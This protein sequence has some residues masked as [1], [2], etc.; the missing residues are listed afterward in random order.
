MSR[1]IHT[2]NCAIYTRKSSE[3]GLEQEFNSLHAQRE[4]CEAYIASQKHEG[5]K[6][7]RTHYEDGGYSGGTMERPGLLALIADIEQGRVQVVV[8]YKVDRLTR[9]LADFSKIIETFDAKG[10]SFVSVTQQ[11]N[12]TT[13]MGR[14]TLNVLLSFAQFEREVTG[15]R[16][17]DKIAASKK[18][19]M[20]MGG[21]VSLGYDC[22]ERKLIVNTAEADTVRHIFQRYLAL[23][24][25]RRLMQELADNGYCSKV[26]KTA[27][28]DLRGGKP[29]A[30][31]ALY[32]I[33]KNRLY[34]GEIVHKEESYPGEHDAI[35]DQDLWQQV[36]DRLSQNRIDRKN[37]SKAREPS[38]LTGIL[39]YAQGRRLTPSHA[40]KNGKRYR[41]YVTANSVNS[42][43]ESTG[44][45]I[46]L[47]ASEMENAVVSEIARFLKAPGELV[48]AL[49]ANVS[50]VGSRKLL[51]E[52]GQA[53]ATALSGNTDAASREFVCSIV[54]RVKIGRKTLSILLSEVA[55]GR[56]LL[57]HHKGITNDKAI[58]LEVPFRLRRR[59]VEAKLI[60]GNQENGGQSDPNHGLIKAI[61]RA[62]VWNRQLISGDSKSVRAIASDLGVTHGYVRKI[63]PLAFLAPDI[64][65]RILAGQQP[66]DLSLTTIIQRG[67]PRSWM[68]QRQLF[69][70]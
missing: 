17:R 34:L 53:L 60:L 4:S 10:V 55:L 66:R 41:Y 31:G 28:G 11:F 50:D 23:G 68:E 22:V 30:R 48:E 33:L 12:T 18:K 51:I 42:E 63:L 44:S 15:E 70:F 25:V 62:Y 7:V 8:V 65:E 35:V 46:R 39:F 54:T 24:C 21:N 38:L 14:L 1:N 58:R 40:N 36:N 47:P 3:E 59:G 69:G 64:V 27:K 57:G 5:W 61:A 26:R 9:A 6:V 56:Q 2:L 52:S 45:A 37:G 67:V 43:M 32:A 20:W 16:I 29:I 49:A 19:G 13:S